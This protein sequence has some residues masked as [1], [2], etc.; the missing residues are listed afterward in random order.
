[1]S[2][3]LLVAVV[4][5]AGCSFPQPSSSFTCETSDDCDGD[6]VCDQGFCVLGQRVVVPDAAIDAPPPDADPFAAIE[7][8]CIAA[9]YTK[10]P[11]TGGYYR[12]VTNT[13]RTWLNA[14]ADCKDDV[15]DATHLIVLSTTAEVTY[16]DTLLANDAWIG[17]SDRAAEGTFVTV[18]GETDDQRPFRPGEPNNGDGGEDCV[19][20]RGNGGLDDVPC[21][22]GFRYI[23]EC[24]GR[25]STP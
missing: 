13:A 21:G 14:Q 15:A 8:L 12:P 3:R 4:A 23:C 7:P 1:M 5:S 25:P 6:R 18:T 9:G 11:T 10:D 17:L 2:H 16:M 22:N 20:M 19:V 24:D